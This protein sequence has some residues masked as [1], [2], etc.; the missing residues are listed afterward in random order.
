MEQRN[1]REYYVA[2]AQASRAF[3]LHATD[4]RIASIHDA[5][6][7]RYDLLA[8]EVGAGDGSSRAPGKLIVVRPLAA[9]GDADSFRRSPR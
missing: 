6:A 1:Y 4:A 3:A 9:T 8:D 2:R 5:F 7:D